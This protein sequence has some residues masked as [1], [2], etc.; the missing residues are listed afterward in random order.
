M[1]KQCLI[2]QTT[3]I[4]A[5]LLQKVMILAIYEKCSTNVLLEE[6]IE[7]LLQKYETR[8]AAEEQKR[9]EAQKGLFDTE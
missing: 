7:D 1:E 5:D 3:T 6:A 8:K 4:D 9:Q 2:K